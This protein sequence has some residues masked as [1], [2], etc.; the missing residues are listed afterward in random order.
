MYNGKMI[1]FSLESGVKSIL[2]ERIFPSVYRC[3]IWM[4]FSCCEVHFCV[5]TWYD[6]G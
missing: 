2:M 1:A 3:S 6:K 4:D 5:F